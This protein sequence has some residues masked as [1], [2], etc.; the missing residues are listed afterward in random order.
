MISKNNFCTKIFVSLLMFNLSF[1]LAAFAGSSKSPSAKRSTASVSQDELTTFVVEDVANIN[2][3]ITL[4]RQELNELKTRLDSGSPMAKTGATI[5]VTTGL[6]TVL[7]GTGFAIKNKSFRGL[8][9]FAAIGGI[10]IASGVASFNLSNENRKSLRE[11]VSLTEER[12]DYL[13]E[14]NIRVSDIVARGIK[15][16]HKVL[17]KH[18]LNERLAQ[19]SSSEILMEELTEQLKSMKRRDTTIQV[20]KWPLYLVGAASLVLGYVGLRDIGRDPHGVAAFFSILGSFG[21][22]LTIPG[23]A[24]LAHFS[25]EDVQLMEEKIQLIRDS[26][27]E[28]KDYIS[29]LQ[30]VL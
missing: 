16:E 6:L 8:G 28:Q 17:I 19:V 10:T 4:R 24:T 26:L 21:A 14:M 11:L 5:S 29:R 18:L 12:L 25:S 2:Q 9:V 30:T 7:L 3:L 13:S 23:A 22:L 1:P 27:A 20:V 15:D